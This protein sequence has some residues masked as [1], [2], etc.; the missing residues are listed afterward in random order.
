[1]LSV[2]L[3]V[4]SFQTGKDEFPVNFSLSSGFQQMHPYNDLSD[5][6]LV[7]LIKRDDHDAYREIYYRYTGILFT[8]AYSKLQDRDEAKDL[9]QDVLS[10]LWL[11]RYT[12]QIQTNISGYLYVSLRNMIINSIAHKKIQTEYL[13]S[14][15][16]YLNK[17]NADTD[18]LTRTNQL[19]VIIEAEVSKMPVRMREIFEL[20]RK[21]HLTHRQIAEKLGISEKTVKDHVNNALKILRIKLGMFNYLV[22]LLF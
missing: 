9:V 4:V 14:L 15:Q 13:D 16:E 10:N 11:K 5:F 3:P 17:N 12:V 18:F 1:L 2:F 8:H 7:A 22:F 19:M 20:S 6:E 21:N